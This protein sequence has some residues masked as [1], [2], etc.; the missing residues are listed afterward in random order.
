MDLDVD[1]TAEKIG[2]GLFYYF[3]AAVAITTEA[4]AEKAG[5]GL[6]YCFAAAV[7][8]IINWAII[9]AAKK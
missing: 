3:A 1:A 7:M 9:V 5:F 6:F 8:E 2:F 4:L